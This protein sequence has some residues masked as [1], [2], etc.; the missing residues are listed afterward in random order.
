MGGT[1]YVF[2][3][4]FTENFEIRL[5]REKQTPAD[6]VHLERTGTLEAIL[7]SSHRDLMTSRFQ[8]VKITINTL[9]VPN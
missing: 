1:L 6:F 7:L 4:A 5:R 2:L 8:S 9:N 3:T